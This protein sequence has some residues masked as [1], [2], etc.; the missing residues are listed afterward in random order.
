[1]KSGNVGIKSG[2]GSDVCADA[3][4]ALARRVATGISYFLFPFPRS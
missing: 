3:R 2:N 1:M 4:G